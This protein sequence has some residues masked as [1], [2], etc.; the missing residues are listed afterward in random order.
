VKRLLNAALALVIPALAFAAD[1]LQMQATS[2]II[3]E[4]N[5][6]G[7]DRYSKVTI[8][9][10]SSD[11]ITF[12]HAAGVAT[13]VLTD[14]DDVNKDRLFPGFLAAKTAAETAQ[15]RA[16][17]EQ[18]RKLEEDQRSIEAKLREEI[19]EALRVPD[20]KREATE[21]FACILVSGRDT[22]ELGDYPQF[23][24]RIL[25]RSSRE[26]YLV[27]SLDGSTSGRR[28]PTCRFEVTDAAGKPVNWPGPFCGNMG[29][30]RAEDFALV[31]GREAF[32][33]FGKGF[34]PSYPFPVSRQEPGTFAVRFFY[35]TSS[36]RVSDYFGAYSGRE[37]PVKPE[38]QQRFDQIPH[39]E[40][41]SKELKITFRPKSK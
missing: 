27:G 4:L 8:T 11:R 32:N 31:P 15:R 10:R 34:F 30:L 26:V 6:T 5:T 28:F 22:Y 16:E 38:I 35:S 12:Q 40:L 19:S 41:R 21:P 20:G 33:P 1:T 14:F 2:G 37:F 25:N 7:G 9:N 13:R 36:R 3:P 24:V 39:V 29:L 23:A 17:E 18:R